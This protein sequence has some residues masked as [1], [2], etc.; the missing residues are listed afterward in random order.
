MKRQKGDY[1][2]K[3]LIFVLYKCSMYFG[4]LRYCLV[5]DAL[6]LGRDQGGAVKAG[7]NLNDYAKEVNSQNFTQIM[8]RTN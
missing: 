1:L 3:P 7:I 2:L 6:R 4:K 8:H 5:T